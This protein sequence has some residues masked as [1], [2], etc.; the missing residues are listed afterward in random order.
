MTVEPDIPIMPWSFFIDEEKKVVMGLNED[1]LDII[2]EAGY[3]TR[4][5][6]GELADRNCWP[7]MCA[8]VPSSVQIKQPAGGQRKQE[9]NLE[10]RRY[11]QNMFRLD[12]FEKQI[13]YKI[14][15]RRKQLWRGLAKRENVDL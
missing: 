15:E 9:S 13:K 8:Y 3:L 4:L 1:T 2:E 6:I 10:K 11:D 12:A 5:E 14:D 7:H